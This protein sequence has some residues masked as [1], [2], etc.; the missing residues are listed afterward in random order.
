MTDVRVTLEITEI[1]QSAS[2]SQ[3]ELLEVVALGIIAPQDNSADDWRFEPAALRELKRAQ[4][5]RQDLELDWAG[6]A[7]A[8]SLLDE[9]S[10]L[11]TENSRLHQRLDRFLI[12]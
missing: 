4:R 11:K 7:L 12:K 9:I 10:R 6:I 3:D 2:I 1:C 5:L 8:V